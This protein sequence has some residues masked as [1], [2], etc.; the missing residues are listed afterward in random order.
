M[1]DVKETQQRLESASM[2]AVAELE[3]AVLGSLSGQGENRLTATQS[4]DISIHR[5]LAE[6]VNQDQTTQLAIQGASRPHPPTTHTTTTSKDKTWL[7][8]GSLSSQTLTQL[9]SDFS[10]GQ[11]EVITNEWAQL[12][13]RLIT[14]FHDGYIA[15]DLEAG[16]F[17]CRG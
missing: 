6:P 14:K 16:M 13:P 7:E 12:L 11:V 4:S 3:S 8:S 10:A 5:N 1:V 17:L 9:L 15:S 2:A